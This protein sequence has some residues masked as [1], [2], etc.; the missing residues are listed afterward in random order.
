MPSDVRDPHVVLAIDSQ[1]MRL[2]DEFIA[3]RAKQFAINI[4]AENR[5]LAAMK[6]QQLPFAVRRHGRTRSQRILGGQLEKLFHRF[7]YHRVVRQHRTDRQRCHIP[8]DT[9]HF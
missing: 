6:Q 2:P 9:K 5:M 7:Q 1:P 8:T 3:P 4:H